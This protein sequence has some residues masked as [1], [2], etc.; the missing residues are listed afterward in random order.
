MLYVYIPVLVIIVL[1]LILGLMMYSNKQ[2]INELK[3]DSLENEI[4]IKNMIHAINYNDKYLRENQKYVYSVYEENNSFNEI[5]D[6][7][8]DD[9]NTTENEINKNAQY[10]NM[11]KNYDALTSLS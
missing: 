3:D 10:Y 5:S 8:N 11:M 1:V 6:T 2:V 9:T 7:K 4:V